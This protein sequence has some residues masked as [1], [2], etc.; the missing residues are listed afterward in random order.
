MSGFSALQTLMHTAANSHF[1]PFVQ[2]YCIAA[3]GR[4]GSLLPFAA[5]WPNVC[6]GPVAPV[7]CDLVEVSI[8]RTAD[9]DAMRS[10]GLLT[11]YSVEKL[12]FGPYRRTFFAMQPDQ[13][14]LAKGSAKLAFRRS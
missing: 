8:V 14:V 1:P 11:A 5:L 12:H 2:N 7:G 6:F 3:F 9:L 10:E 13:L 4:M